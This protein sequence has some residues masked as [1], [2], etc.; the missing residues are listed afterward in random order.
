[1]PN[2]LFSKNLSVWYKKQARDLPWRR[3]S[4]PYK[5]WISEVMLQQTTV[6]A[7]VPY[8]EKWLKEFPTVHDVAAAS[9]Q[10]IL[11]IWQGLGYYK[12]A[13]NIHKS[14]QMMAGQY[15]GKIPHDPCELKKLPGFGPYTIG[16]VLSIAF[17]Q[18]QPIIDANVRRVVMR[19]KAI[20]GHA[21]SAQDP[22]ILKF[23]DEV[24]PQKGN[25]IFNQAL[26][27]LGALICRNG[28]PLCLLCPVRSAC[29]AY[30]QGKQSGIPTLRKR[31]IK[32]IDAVIALIQKSGKYFIQRRP[33]QGLFADLWEFPGG[34]IEKGETPK[35]ALYREVKEELDTEIQ[36]ANFLFQVQQF[37]TQ[38]KANLHVWSC[39]LKSYPKAD[40]THKWVTQ[41]NFDRYPMPSGSVKIVQRLAAI[42][43]KMRIIILLIFLLVGSAASSLAESSIPEGSSIELYKAGALQ[44]DAA[45]EKKP[46][47]LPDGLHVTHYKNGQ[48]H[49]EENYKKGKRNGL[50]KIYY[51][52]GKLL[53]E[54]AYKDNKLD[55]ELK[56]YGTNGKLKVYESYR[57]GLRDGAF[58][59]YYDAGNL[60][61]EKVYKNAKL[62]SLKR[63]QLNSD[64]IV[65][66]NYK[67]D[68]KDGFVRIYFADGKL[69]SEKYYKADQLDGYSKIYYA[70]GQL[71]E[72]GNYTLGRK[73]GVFK[74]YF[75]NGNLQNETV[76]KDNIMEGPFKDYYED[77]KGKGEGNYKLN[78]FNGLL[79]QYAPDGMLAN[80]MTYTLG[81]LNGPARQYFSSGKL[82][83]EG[84]FQYNTQHGPYKGYYEN[85]RVREE[86]KYYFGQQDGVVKF[87]RDNGILEGEETYKKDVLV[88]V[89]NYD[90]AGNLITDK[91]KKKK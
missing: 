55:G 72:E 1:M 29:Q 34:K 67:N 71:S 5:I 49:Y 59:N 47:P 14:A 9:L 18:R 24:M 76:Y 68:K 43:N 86:G 90:A 4:D 11:R 31:E 30:A 19:L 42:H 63:Y 57:Q 33:A 10:K 8:Y 60:R 15:Q 7:V 39:D 74:L 20:E 25:N 69:Q 82:S 3:T 40:T 64:P 83:Y 46:A 52:N 56:M 22:N 61:E 58:Q 85:G 28:E 50:T 26:M 75:P 66:E 80:E 89:K 38:F 36:S 44:I 53:M 12:R 48:V 81:E 62:I 65:E 17:D 35:A 2:K 54:K 77:G 41:K 13:K 87:Y 23:L 88:D 79:K 45:Q 51:P 27:E 73:N 16:A 32:E 70:G 37:Y 84:N 6:A 91:S 78:V 21:D